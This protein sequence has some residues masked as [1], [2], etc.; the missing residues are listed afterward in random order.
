AGSGF[1]LSDLL[2]ASLVTFDQHVPLT[3][4]A[5]EALDP[6]AIYVQYQT[7]DPVTME[8]A[9]LVVPAQLSLDTYVGPEFNWDDYTDQQ[10]EIQEEEE[11]EEFDVVVDQQYKLYTKCLGDPILSRAARPLS[12]DA[13]LAPL[14]RETAFARGQGP[15]SAR[16]S[17]NAKP[18]LSASTLSSFSKAAGRDKF[19]QTRLSELDAVIRS[20]GARVSSGAWHPQTPQVAW[21][22]K[23]KL[24]TQ[25][26]QILEGAFSDRCVRPAS[27]IPISAMAEAL[28]APCPAPTRGKDLTAQVAVHLFR[29]QQGNGSSGKEA[30]DDSEEAG[31]EEEQRGLEAEDGEAAQAELIVGSSGMGVPVPGTRQAHLHGTALLKPMCQ[32]LVSSILVEAS[33]A[34]FRFAV[35]GDL[36]SCASEENRLQLPSVCA[37]WVRTIHDVGSSQVSRRWLHLLALMLMPA[38]CSNAELQMQELPGQ[39]FPPCDLSEI[40]VAEECPAT[41]STGLKWSSYSGE[42][43]QARAELFTGGAKASTLAVHQLLERATLRFSDAFSCT[44]AL[45]STYFSLARSLMLQGRLRRALSFIQMGFIFVRDRGFSECSSWPA[46]GWDVM[47]AGRSLTARVRA[48]DDESVLEV[49]KMHRVEGM[50]VAVVTI[51]SYAVDEPVKLICDQNRKLYSMLHGYDVHFF[52]DP[53]QITPNRGSQMD[54]LDGVHKAFFWKVNA[55][56]NVLETKKYDWVLWMDCDAFFMDP[57]RTIDSVIAMYSNTTAPSRLG[58]A[59]QSEAPEIAAVRQRM[60]PNPAVDV[61]LIFAVDSTGINNGVW[62]LKDTPWSHRFLERWWRSDILEGPGKEHNCSDQSTMLHTLLHENAMQLDEAWDS[63]EAPVWPPEVRVAAQE[64]LQS[65]HDATAATALSR[66]WQDGDFIKHHPGCHYY[67]EPCQ[68][69]YSHAQDIFSNKVQA[70]YLESQATRRSFGRLIDSP[71]SPA[72]AS[73]SR[74]A[75]FSALCI[76]DIWFG[77]EGP[78]VTQLHDSGAL[79]C[80]YEVKTSV[81]RADQQVKLSVHVR[82]SLYKNWPCVPKRQVATHLFAWGSAQ[83][84]AEH[85]DVVDDK[86]DANEFAL[87][88]EGRPPAPREGSLSARTTRPRAGSS[89]HPG[90]RKLLLPGARQLLRLSKVFKRRQHYIVEVSWKAMIDYPLPVDD[91]PSDCSGPATHA[92]E[93]PVVLAPGLKNSPAECQ[94]QPTKSIMETPSRMLEW[95][96]TEEAAAE[97]LTLDRTSLLFVCNG[98]TGE[99]HSFWV[100]L[101]LRVL[102]VKRLVEDVIGLPADEMRLSYKGRLLDE[103]RTLLDSGVEDCIWPRL[104][105]HTCRA[106]ATVPPCHALPR[107]RTSPG[108]HCALHGGDSKANA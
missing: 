79:P 50:R 45:I 41:T 22:D 25:E 93:A 46:Q 75:G 5:P 28:D 31:A 59:T 104:E 70:L 19:S 40:P 105:K 60:M 35:F 106:G 10:P 3:S 2:G 38:P 108:A 44:P 96:Q 27:M 85:V 29:A 62:L 23:R 6:R 72:Q 84:A 102:A 76:F 94:F 64:Y 1:H 32:G 4:G 73:R 15:A 24:Q 18:A 11:D 66:A 17:Q 90:A 86:Y 99:K 101:A 52:T 49:P 81:E 36:S 13:Y 63:V 89:S 98:T 39:N 47:L 100:A 14:R 43:Y 82:R 74:R 8:H 16:R 103:K 95:Q 61:S 77:F 87:R 67:K 107:P 56:K 51:C 65:F 91:K 88:F 30:G 37:D 57:Q 68:Y 83:R 53:S 55:V 54:V 33:L 92:L 26:G 34:G 12:P 21:L 48:L 7:V 42:L 71:E 97:P 58:P 9:S 78:T 80:E 69:L 20:T